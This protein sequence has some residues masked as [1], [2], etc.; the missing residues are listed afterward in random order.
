MYEGSCNCC[1]RCCTGT[2]FVPELGRTVVGVCE[3]LESVGGLHIGSADATRCKVYSTRY[4]GM[5]IVLRAEDSHCIR[6]VCTP[7]FPE[8]L[9]GVHPDCSYRWVGPDKPQFIDIHVLKDSK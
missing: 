4:R 1:G 2:F 5:P 6:S 8:T 9:N 3:N 7:E